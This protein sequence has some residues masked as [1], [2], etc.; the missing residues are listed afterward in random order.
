[1]PHTLKE[2]LKWL[3][4]YGHRWNPKWPNLLNVDAGR[5]A[6]MDGSEQDARALV[7]SWQELDANVRRAVF[8]AHGRPL[9]PDGIIG[10]A[11][12]FVMEAKRC[13]M[14]DFAPPPGASFHYDDPALQL[15]VESMQRAVERQRATGSGSWPA[16]CYG[17]SGVHEIKVSYDLSGLSEKQ[18]EWMPEVKRHN[19]AAVAAMGLKV[20]EVPVGEFANVRFFQR[21]FGGSTIGM[22]EFN[23][24]ECG[25]SVFCT[26]TNRYGPNLR[27][28]LILVMHEFGHTMNFQ[29][30]AG[31]IMNPSI[32]DVP[33]W[34]VRWDADGKIT[35]KD[36]RYA[37]GTQFF[38]GQPLT[39]V[40]PPPPPPPPPPP[41]ELYWF[42][43]TT[44]MQGDPGV[45]LQEFLIVRK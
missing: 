10:P 2:R 29:H 31:Y 19:A 32:M 23:S 40:T 39:P 41:S 35:Y 21:T 12:E 34:W 17:T 42:E 30:S 22:A 45:P 16:G 13:S 9:E 26:V 3:S 25:D 24:G 14:P 20:V 15:A 11:S 43:G 36:V 6:L 18:K 33:E 27:M 4:D 44:L 5:V 1:M 37:K 8:L 28:F 38:G 7:A